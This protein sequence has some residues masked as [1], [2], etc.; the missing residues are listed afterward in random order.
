MRRPL[1]SLIAGLVLGSPML[2][3]AHAQV[4]APVQAVTEAFSTE[5]V[6]QG[7]GALAGVALFTWVIA[8]QAAA[9]GQPFSILGSRLTAT[10]LA[11]TGAV[12]STFATDLWAGRPLNHAYAWHRGGFAAGVAAWFGVTGLLGHPLPLGNDWLLWSVDRAALLGAGTAGAWIVDSWA[13]AEGKEKA[14]TTQAVGAGTPT[15]T[16]R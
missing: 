2:R 15:V 5:L 1:I 3:P 6:A 4:T 7:A 11:G 8:P 12:V 9:A 16:G 14:P 13:R 10:M